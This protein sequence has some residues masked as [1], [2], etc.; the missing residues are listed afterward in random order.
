MA[1]LPAERV[2]GPRLRLIIWSQ[3]HIIYMPQP[4][5]P[6]R[7]LAVIGVI[8]VVIVLFGYLVVRQN[9][10]L[11]KFAGI[12]GAFVTLALVSYIAINPQPLQNLNVFALL[13]IFASIAVAMFGATIP[14]FLQISYETRNWLT[15]SAVG[16]LALFVATFFFAPTNLTL[17]GR[18]EK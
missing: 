18:R 4:Q 15:I 10:S 11:D 6:Y 3:S 12:I 7:R 13:R 8:F 16:A 17:E 2:S 1:P 14:G 9:L 5:H